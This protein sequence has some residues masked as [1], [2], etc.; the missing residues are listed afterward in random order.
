MA[1]PHK[2]VSFLPFSARYVAAAT[3]RLPQPQP[4][5]RSVYGPRHL[6]EIAT[7][8]ARLSI[9]AWLLAAAFDLQATRIWGTERPSSP[10]G[11]DTK[12]IKDNSSG[13]ESSV[14]EQVSAC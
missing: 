9:E 3:G 5:Q 6:R 7:E 13:D 11:I 12:K 2:R 1:L 14:L 10:A 4:Q 8:D